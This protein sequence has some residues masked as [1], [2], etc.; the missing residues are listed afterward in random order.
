MYSFKDIQ[1][2]NLLQEAVLDILKDETTEEEMEDY[3]QGLLTHGCISGWCSNL[4][5]YSDTLAFYKQH[6]DYINDMVKD[7]L[8][9]FGADC[10]SSV[11][12]KKFDNE[13]PLIQETTN[14]NLLCWFSFEETVRQF[15]LQLDMEV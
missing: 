8:W 6:I 3:I 13:D 1:T 10:M 2:E 15:A 5:Y 4:V 14:Q 11:F 12:G 9:E 7:T